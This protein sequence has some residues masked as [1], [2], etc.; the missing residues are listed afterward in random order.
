M[1]SI[2]NGRCSVT[3]VGLLPIPEG[4]VFIVHAINDA[5]VYRPGSSKQ[6]L[7]VPEVGILDT[8]LNPAA[9]LSW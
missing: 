8:M 5:L 9:R 3:I 4:S 1:I 7:F 6:P 2:F